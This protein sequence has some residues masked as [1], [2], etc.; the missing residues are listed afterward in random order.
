MILG[1]AKVLEKEIESYLLT[2]QKA[3]MIFREAM[4][5]YL[6]GE[7]DLFSERITKIK[8]LESGADKLRTNIEHKLYI[9]MLIPESRGDVLGLL[10][11][12]DNVAD[13]AQR[14]LLIIDIERP[15]IPDTMK[16]DFLKLVEYSENAISEQ[17]KAVRSFFVDT[18][19]TPNYTSRVYFFEHEVDTIAERLKRSIF[20]SKD[21]GHLSTK[22]HLRYFIDEMVKL[23]DAA[24]DVC[25]RL[26]I[27]VI[28][29]SM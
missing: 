15:S 8:E 25:E 4:K 13:E 12:M 20:A 22:M 26:S 1:K 6:N 29:R 11:T 5:E 10:E 3:G 23:S 2:I 28:K 21:I 7:L 16:S 18:K 14:L 24:E 19:M 27:S 17:V 9:H